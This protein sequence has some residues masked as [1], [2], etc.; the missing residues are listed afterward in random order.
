MKFLK[1]H[2]AHGTTV[3]YKYTHVCVDPITVSQAGED[4]DNQDGDGQ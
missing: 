2:T 1:M 4:G 3:H